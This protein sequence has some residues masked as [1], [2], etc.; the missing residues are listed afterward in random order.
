MPGHD[1]DLRPTSYDHPDVVALTALAQEFYVEIYGGPDRTPFTAEE[2]S[3][4]HG[5]FLVG[6]LGNRPVAMG[7]WRISPYAPPAGA[8]RA[9]EI[10]RMFAHP[11]ARGHG[12]ARALLHALEDGALAAGADWMV[13][14][15]GRPQTAAIAFYR[16]NGYLDIEPFGFYAAEPDV[17]SLGKRLQVTARGDDPP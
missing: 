8:R 2:F 16:A 7:G 11:E 17:V 3:A 13:L 5:G 15:T 1:L 6:Y 14:E 12:H 9:A 4:P 10:K